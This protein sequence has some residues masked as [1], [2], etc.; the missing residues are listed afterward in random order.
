M[1]GAEVLSKSNFNIF[2]RMLFIPVSLFLPKLDIISIISLL[3]K[4]DIRSDFSQGSVK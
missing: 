4:G 2:I 3:A 1:L